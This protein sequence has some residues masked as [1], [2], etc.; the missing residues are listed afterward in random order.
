MNIEEDLTCKCCNEIFKNPITLNCCGDNIC[1]DHIEQLITNS[2]S[3]QFACPL[4]NKDNVN[5]NLNVNKFMQKMVENELYKFKISSKYKKT[6]EQLK[7]EIQKIEA[8]VKDP[9]NFIYEEISELKRNVDLD[10]E[11]LKCEI[12]DLANDLIQQLEKYEK[13]FKEEYKSNIDLDHY[14][15]IIASS[16]KQ[17]SE[18]EKCLSLFST[19]KKERNEKCYQSEKTI[20]FVQSM[21]KETKFKLFA[22]TFLT[23]IPMQKSQGDLFGKLI[24][25]VSF[26]WSSYFFY[27][28]FKFFFVK[29]KKKI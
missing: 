4:C 19:S 12:D 8:I 20:N 17:L 3:N 13:K 23:Y 25:K 29:I 24:V 2:T 22:N 18:F 14:N 16:K 1:K 9:K 6:L 11:K 28:S 15:E 26:R 27:S 5:Q 21:I 10:R 7:W